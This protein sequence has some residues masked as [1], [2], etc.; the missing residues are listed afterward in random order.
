MQANPTET[1]SVPRPGSSLVSF[2]AVV[3]IAVVL[4]GDSAINGEWRTVE[5][6][7]APALLVVWAA[8]ILLF[9]PSIRFDR[10]TVTVHNPLRVIRVPWARVSAVSQRFQV[11]LEL[12]DGK[13]VTCWGSPFPEKPG[14][15]RQTPARAGRAL[16]ATDVASKL[17]SARASVRS[18]S[19]DTQVVRRFD[20]VAVVVGAIVLL[21]CAVELVFALLLS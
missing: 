13:K 19:S 1:T 3:L 7:L 21:A 6:T 11:V 17:E 4:V 2:Y 5:V 9:R 12:D 20:L 14:A 18:G 15:R 10:E 8:W 16:L